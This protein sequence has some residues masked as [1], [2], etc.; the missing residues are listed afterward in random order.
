[1]MASMLYGVRPYDMAVFL[2]VPMLLLAVAA[3]ASY[4][5]ARRATKMNPI[6]ALRES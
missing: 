2:I 1:M 3:V 5:P 6:V 4:L